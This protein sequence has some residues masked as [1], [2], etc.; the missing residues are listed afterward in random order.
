MS[1]LQNEAEAGQRKVGQLQRE[2]ES[3]Q[4]ELAR[5]LDHVEHGR[6]DGEKENAELKQQVSRHP[7]TSSTLSRKPFEKVLYKKT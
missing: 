7:Y 6:K 3:C 1:R 4:Q 5:C 2:L